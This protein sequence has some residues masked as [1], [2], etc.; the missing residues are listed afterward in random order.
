MAG[1]KPPVEGDKS[2]S[3]RK[4]NI[5]EDKNSSAEKNLKGEKPKDKAPKSNPKGKDTSIHS[6][7]SK[8]SKV[9]AGKGKDNLE[10]TPKDVDHGSNSTQTQEGRPNTS[11]GESGILSQCMQALRSE[12][13]KMMK[14]MMDSMFDQ[15]KAKLGGYEYGN[16]EANADTIQNQNNKDVNLDTV[17]NYGDLDSDVLDV[18]ANQAD[19]FDGDLNTAD[20]FSGTS[21]KSDDKLSISESCSQ[22]P[23]EIG[24]DIKW[25]SILKQLPSYYPGNLSL[26]GEES[27]IHK[28]FVSQAL[29]GPKKTSNIPKLPLEGTMK[30]RW[31]EIDR[32]VKRGVVSAY[33]AKDKNR[34]RVKE[35]DFEKYGAVPRI[36]QDYKAK[37]ELDAQS[38]KGFG[39]KSEKS[40]PVIRDSQLRVAESEFQKC[41]ESARLIL[42]ASS[43]ATLMLNAINTI[44]TD[45]TKYQQNEALNLVQGVFES[46][47]S[48]ADCAIRVTA[49]SVLARRRICLSQLNFKDSNAK[50]ELMKLPMDGKSLFHGELSQVMHKCATFARD[51]RETSDYASVKQK[52]KRSLGQ[53]ANSGPPFKKQAVASSSG[54]QVQVQGQARKI[55]FK[56][57]NE[58]RQQQT[59]SKSTPQFQFQSKR[60][61]NK[62]GNKNQKY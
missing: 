48:M 8:K 36:D 12:N 9:S 10:T 18:H 39:S 6:N 7:T 34:F 21:E 31:D 2:D 37:L 17:P 56:K 43:H 32:S 23:S 19:D 20:K 59:A 46:L 29:Q 13:E 1:D 26:D 35:D 5:T 22:A 55:T 40:P 28:S 49:R 3:A 51:A 27:E 15:M 61:G 38:R 16:P 53:N 60:N 24:E 14:S 4:K 41:D 50:G 47:Q 30:Q 62:W 33:R 57:P 42:R 44:I 45:P 54:P 25:A 11:Q 52:G 58:P